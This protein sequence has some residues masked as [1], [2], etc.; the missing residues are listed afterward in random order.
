MN[1]TKQFLATALLT[2]ALC[3]LGF[4]LFH[5]NLVGLGYTFFLVVPFCIGYFLGVKLNWSLSLVIGVMIGL[6]AF[7]FLLITAQLEGIV[8]VIILLPI[9][10]PIILLGILLGYN[11]KNRQ[12]KKNKRDTIM[13]SLY[14]LL[15]LLFSG[16]I[17]HF[18]SSKY[19]DARVESTIHLPYDA[20]TVYDFIKS[21]DTLEGKKSILMNLGLPTP[22]KCELEKEEVGARRT[23][24]FETGKIEEKVTDIKRGEYIKMKVTDYEMLGLKWLKF[25]DAIYLFAK[26]DSMTKVTRITTYHSQLKPR[27]YWEFWEKQAIEAQHEYVLNDLKRRLDGRKIK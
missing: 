10:I 4:F 5:F 11:I 18:F 17:E 24:Y 23:C 14:P 25:D 1:R 13:I 9:F 12:L 27:I 26:E 16:T 15:I 2:F 7:F 21:V 6:A 22:Q 19:E 3:I 20:G 8:C